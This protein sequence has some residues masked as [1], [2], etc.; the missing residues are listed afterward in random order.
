[1]R[2]RCHARRGARPRCARGTGRADRSART[3]ICRR[4]ALEW[5]RA[6][7]RSIGASPSSLTTPAHPTS[8]RAYPAFAGNAQPD[9]QRGGSDSSDA[10]DASR[11]LPKGERSTAQVRVER[12]ASNGERRHGEGRGKA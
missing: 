6:R 1:M 2:E 9:G 7:R 12:G 5:Q 3:G 11:H 8:A 4:R 10:R